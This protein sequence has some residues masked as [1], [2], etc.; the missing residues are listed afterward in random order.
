MTPYSLFQKMPVLLGLVHLPALPGAPH[1]SV[2]L[3]HTRTALRR[4]LQALYRDDAH[5]VEALFI[6]GRAFVS[7]VTTACT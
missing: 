1:Y 5:A 2:N 7:A 3:S 4:N 6:H